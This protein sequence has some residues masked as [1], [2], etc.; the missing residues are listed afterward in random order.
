MCTHP[1]GTPIPPHP[2]RRPRSGRAQRLDQESA[3]LAAQAGPRARLRTDQPLRR[4][5]H[6]GSAGYLAA[7]RPA[8]AR[9]GRTGLRPPP[10]RPLREGRPRPSGQRRARRL[11]FADPAIVTSRPPRRGGRHVLR[12]GPPVRSSR[13]R[14][15]NTP[16]SASDPSTTGALSTGRCADRAGRPLP[17]RPRAWFRKGAE[18][19][20]RTALVPPR[21]PRRRRPVPAEPPTRL[22]PRKSRR[23]A[24]HGRRAASARSAGVR[25][26][27]GSSARS[28]PHGRSSSTARRRRLDSGRQAGQG[29]L[30]PKPA[31]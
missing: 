13:G 17:L 26:W 8:P 29:Q 9:G 20:T 24:G 6:D 7:Q 27:R 25:T 31:Q 14:P 16:R 4:G 3:G 28:P 21:S 11:G 15:F 19:R 22:R 2:D 18:R 23:R 5:F 1:A 10:Q 12:Q 30:G